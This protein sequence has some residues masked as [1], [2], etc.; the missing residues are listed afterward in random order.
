MGFVKA[1]AD[2]DARKRLER[3]VGRGVL[4]AYPERAEMIAARVAE[5]E[6]E[7]EVRSI[8]PAAERGGRGNPAV[9][10]LGIAKEKLSVA[11]YAIKIQAR[12]VR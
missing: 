7:T 5:V 4:S 6:A 3:A 10:A 1:L 12:C 11:R 2:S 8:R 9:T